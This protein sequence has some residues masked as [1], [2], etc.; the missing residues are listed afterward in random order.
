MFRLV[1]FR[2]HT[3]LINDYGEVHKFLHSVAV[4]LESITHESQS[5]QSWSRHKK[6]SI[7]FIFEF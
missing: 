2:A 6:I 1:I 5:L 3:L 7:D 4:V